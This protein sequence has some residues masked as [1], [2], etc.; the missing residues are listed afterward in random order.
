M[1]DASTSLDMSTELRK[2]AVRAKREPAAWSCPA[3]VDSSL[4][5]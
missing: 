3:L 4:F 1:T 5:T 2:V